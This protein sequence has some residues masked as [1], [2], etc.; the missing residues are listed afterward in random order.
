MLRV[1]LRTSSGKTAWLVGR[2]LTWDELDG[3][4]MD[5]FRATS[6][7]RYMA[8]GGFHIAGDW[9]LVEVHEVPDEDYPL[10]D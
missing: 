1:T 7:G 3:W 8:C 9:R 10:E 6:L 2:L 5:G 4:H